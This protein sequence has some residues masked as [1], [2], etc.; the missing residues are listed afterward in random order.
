M[1]P[2]VSIIIIHRQKTVCFESCTESIEFKTRMNTDYKISR[3]AVNIKRYFIY[4][5]SLL[6]NV[7]IWSTQLFNRLWPHMLV[8]KHS[9]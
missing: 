2:S 8:L 9:L 3:A 7:N 6:S 1:F 5:S 4:A